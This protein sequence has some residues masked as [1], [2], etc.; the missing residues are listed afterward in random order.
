MVKQ[1]L[2][3]LFDVFS[4]MMSFGLRFIKFKYA[5]TLTTVAIFIYIIFSLIF[6]KIFDVAYILFKSLL[7]DYLQK[8]YSVF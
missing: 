8:L 2:F 7:N 1:I 5:V 6:G 3:H 4:C